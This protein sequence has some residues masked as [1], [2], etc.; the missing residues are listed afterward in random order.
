MIYTL[1]C[2]ERPRTEKAFRASESRLLPR[3]IQHIDPGL[4]DLRARHEDAPKL[5]C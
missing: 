2:C 3:D 1:V 4:E 5:L